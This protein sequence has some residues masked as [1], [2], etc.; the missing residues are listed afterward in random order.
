MKLSTIISLF[1]FLFFAILFLGGPIFVQA[2]GSDSF[3]TIENPFKYE[4]IEDIIPVITELLKGIALGIGTIMVIWAGIQIMTAGG[5]E[6]QLKK[7]KKTMTWTIIG[8]AVVV[9]VD[10]IVGFIKELIVKS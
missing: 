4:K 6:E 8:V 2:Q 5:N 3:I 1:L 10:F 9:L 7:G